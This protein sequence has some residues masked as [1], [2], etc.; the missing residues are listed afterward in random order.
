MHLVLL[1]NHDIKFV[2][3]AVTDS[4]TVFR[5]FFDRRLSLK[6]L[7]RSFSDTIR[8][9]KLHGLGTVRYAFSSPVVSY[10]IVKYGLSFNYT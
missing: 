6:I 3:S 10:C 9:T 5:I 8:Y 2:L 4:V 1:H 7:F